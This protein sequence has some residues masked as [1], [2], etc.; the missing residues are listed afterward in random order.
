MV[1]WFLEEHV[2]FKYLTKNQVRITVSNQNSHNGAML[3]TRCG[4]PVEQTSNNAEDY[5]TGLQAEAKKMPWLVQLF[6]YYDCSSLMSCPVS[7]I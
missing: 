1:F 6:W 7:F 2:K 4:D 3:S 5:A